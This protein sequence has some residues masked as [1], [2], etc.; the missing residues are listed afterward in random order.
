MEICNQFVYPPHE[1]GINPYRCYVT[2]EQYI[3]GIWVDKYTE[4][5]NYDS[6]VTLE[7]IKNKVYYKYKGDNNYRLTIAS[8]ILERNEDNKD[9]I[10]FIKDRIAELNLLKERIAKIKIDFQ[11]DPNEPIYK[12]DNTGLTLEQFVNEDIGE[13]YWY[14]RE[15]WYNNKIQF[16][17]SNIRSNSVE[18]YLRSIINNKIAETILLWE[19]KLSNP[20]NTSIGIWENGALKDE[21]YYFSISGIDFSFSNWKL[22]DYDDKLSFEQQINDQQ[23]HNGYNFIT[24][25]YDEF[26][27]GNYNSIDHDSDI[28]TCEHFLYIENGNFK[29][30][31]LPL[32]RLYGEYGE[33]SRYELDDFQHLI[34]YKSRPFKFY[35]WDFMEC[36]IE[37]EDRVLIAKEIR[38]TIE[39]VMKEEEVTDK[40][41][42]DLLEAIW[43]SRA[44]VLNKLNMDNESFDSLKTKY[45]TLTNNL[46]DIIK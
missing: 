15:I 29:K 8:G 12:C 39:A 19:M 38:S 31:G 24:M 3:N 18:Y 21:L 34:T 10:E 30:I 13:Y 35:S 40:E 42:F 32:K 26:K 43:G 46:W 23:L 16:N 41:Y 1:L 36:D 25:P 17:E 37:L 9:H 6:S 45:I 44:A 4:T 22:V 20:E 11:K 2:I 27:A 28:L 7:E 14:L 33:F 5:L